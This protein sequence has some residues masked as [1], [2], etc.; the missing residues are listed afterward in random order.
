MSDKL[1]AIAKFADSVEAE[2]AKQLLQDFGVK[3]VITGQHAANVYSGLPP[4]ANVGLLAL[5]SQ[6]AQAK[7]ILESQQKQEQ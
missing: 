7:E 4:V 2:M 6:A 1:V 3:A 5:E